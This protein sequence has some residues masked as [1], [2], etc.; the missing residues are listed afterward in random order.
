MTQNITDLL[1]RYL[2]VSKHSVSDKA[3][4]FDLVGFPLG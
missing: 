4:H 3:H 2:L 1:R